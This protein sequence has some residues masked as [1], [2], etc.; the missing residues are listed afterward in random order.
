MD[1]WID[2]RSAGSG[3]KASIKSSLVNTK[4]F[5]QVKDDTRRIGTELGL[6]A[7]GFELRLA[8][9]ANLLGRNSFVK[10]CM[11]P[12][13]CSV[14][15]PPF[16]QLAGC[17]IDSAFHRLS[18]WLVD[19]DHCRLED[20][21]RDMERCIKNPK[22]RSGGRNKERRQSKTSDIATVCWQYKFWRSSS[23][24]ILGRRFPAR[25]FALQAPKSAHLLLVQQA[26][27]IE[28]SRKMKHAAVCCSNVV[29]VASN[30]FG[31][32]SVQN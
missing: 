12:C 17:W 5:P 14:L 6:L 9:L 27:G 13:L 25:P 7:I 4:R 8:G 26:L 22:R 28:V 23:M 1:G 29:T 20:M 16:F 21:W 2:R 19:H 15:P 11:G 32:F 10:S 31:L 24:T 18:P 30:F 3:S